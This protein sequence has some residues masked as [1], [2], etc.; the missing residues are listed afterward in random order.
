[1]MRLHVLQHQRTTIVCSGLSDV[2]ILTVNAVGQVRYGVKI[3]KNL[4]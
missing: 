3:F 1:M 4:M 2:G